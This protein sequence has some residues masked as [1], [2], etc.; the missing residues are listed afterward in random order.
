MLLV[1]RPL[2]P[3]SWISNLF[4]DN[5]WG[6][7]ADPFPNFSGN[8]ETKLQLYV[9][10]QELILTTMDLESV[11]DGAFCGIQK[12][13]KLNLNYNQLRSLPTLCPIKCCL[14]HLEVA[15]NKISWLSK[16][17]FKGFKQLK[18]INLS[19]NNLL[20]LP[21]VHW[22]QDTVSVL[23]A[24]WNKIDSLDALH[25]TSVYTNLTNLAFTV[26]A[27]H[28]FNVS[29]LRHMP[30][31]RYFNLYGNK[32]NHIDDF[33]NLYARN[34]NLRH[35]PLHCD[36]ELSWMGEEDMSFE[37]G[38]TCTTPSCL[39]GMAIADMSK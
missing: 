36:T 26:N 21:D 39:H 18:K 16:H 31:L 8:D 34:I 32:L 19:K 12:L 10:L 27:I 1:K 4:Y 35:N 33:R 6:E 11:E 22:I 30:K 5:V 3:Y 37:K 24:S 29:R 20:V 23:L 17:F 28:S 15:N 2:R 38:L 13:S 14:V 7:I 25:T 9:I